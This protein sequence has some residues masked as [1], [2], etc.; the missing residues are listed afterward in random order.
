MTIPYQIFLI[1]LERYVCLINIIYRSRENLVDESSNNKVNS[2]HQQQNADIYGED[3]DD[4]NKHVGKLYDMND[5]EEPDDVS[6]DKNDDNE[7]EANDGQ[8]NL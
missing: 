1:L 4:E 7:N 8:S 3:D 5:E 6:D 2:N